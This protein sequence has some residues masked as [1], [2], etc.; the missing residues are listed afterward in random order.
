MKYN[1]I[2][3]YFII[4]YVFIDIEFYVILYLFTVDID[5]LNCEDFLVA[6]LRVD[7]QR[8]LVFAT[9]FQLSMLKHA[10]RWF[11]DGTFKVSKTI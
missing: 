3:V 1:Y 4:S 8:H 10:S 5:Y 11:M 2:F 9:E 6:D 7:T